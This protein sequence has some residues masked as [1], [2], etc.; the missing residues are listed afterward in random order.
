MIAG[1]IVCCMVVAVIPFHSEILS[2]STVYAEDSEKE[3]SEKIVN[4]QIKLFFQTSLYDEYI[5]IPDDIP[6]EYQ[7][8]AD[9]Y[10]NCSEITYD[11]ESIT[12]SDGI[13]KPHLKTTQT[14]F[15]GADVTLEVTTGEIGTTELS[16]KKEDTLFC[17]EIEI[18]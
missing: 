16:F 8:P 17:Y 5:S 1:I 18:I 2:V 14:S 3:D 13:I 12:V 6:Q 15:W 7:I 9:E 10:E 11:S 4:K